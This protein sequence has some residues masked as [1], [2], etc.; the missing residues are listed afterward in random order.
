M[1]TKRVS[2]EVVDVEVQLAPFR[3]VS[4]AVTDVEVVLAPFRLVSQELVFVE[5]VAGVPANRRSGPITQCT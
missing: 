5:V 3:L 4:Q 1:S 2:Q